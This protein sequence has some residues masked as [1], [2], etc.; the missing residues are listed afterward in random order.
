M[1]TLEGQWIIEISLC[2]SELMGGARGTVLVTHNLY[3][4][5][6]EPSL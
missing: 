3:D 4:E 6:K 1:I 5:S 2:L